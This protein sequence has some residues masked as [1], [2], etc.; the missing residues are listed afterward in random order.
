MNGFNLW[1]EE[2]TGALSDDNPELSGSD[3]V[4]FFMRQWKA[5]D[6]KEKQEWNKKGKEAAGE[7]IEQGDKKRKREK[8][9]DEN[10]DTSNTLHPAKKTKDTV[11]NGATSGSL[12][13]LIKKTD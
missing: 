6:D 4:K 1:F 8:C 9:D 11:A 3:L 2:S 5:L 10:E 13:L 12:D 7:I